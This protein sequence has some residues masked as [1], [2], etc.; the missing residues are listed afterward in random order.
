MKR[1]AQLFT[2]NFEAKRMAIHFIK[3]KN[4]HR[5]ESFFQE[6]NNVSVRSGGVIL[7]DVMK[8]LIRF[9][10]EEDSGGND[11]S[12]ND[13]SHLRFSALIALISALISS[14]VSPSCAAVFCA[15]SISE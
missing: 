1:I 14:S 12:I 5:S 6:C 15:C 2:S 10:Y 11:I 8:E 4:A 13:D 7:H 3:Q 9:A